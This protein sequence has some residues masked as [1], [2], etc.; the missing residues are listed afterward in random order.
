MPILL[1][2]LRNPD[3]DIA[4]GARYGLRILT[5]RTAKNDLG[6]TPQSQYPQWSA[7]WAHEGGS[8]PIYKAKECGNLNPLP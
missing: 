4:D 3:P 6:E 1:D 8:A 5:H 2:L 7:W